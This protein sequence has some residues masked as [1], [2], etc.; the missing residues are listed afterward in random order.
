MAFGMPPPADD[1][2]APQPALGGMLN[3]FD[4]A[5]IDPA[6]M[7]QWAEAPGPE[8]E[9]IE[10]P[11]PKPI[12]WR[13]RRYWDNPEER[14]RL[15]R[16]VRDEVERYY[17]QVQWRLDNLQEW[18]RD[19]E[20]MPADG[21][22]PWENAATIRAPFTRYVVDAH[23]TR[24]NAQIVQ[25]EPPLIA[26]PEDDEAVA[27]A[28]EIEEA[29][30][31][32][33]DQSEWALTARIL[34][35]D[36]PLAGDCFLRTQFE[37]KKK[38]IPSLRVDFDEQAFYA[39]SLAGLDPLAAQMSA[40]KRDKK[41]AI[42]FKLGWE[43]VVTYAGTTFKFIP[44]EDGI[45][46][47]LTCREQQDARGIGER[48]MISGL[49]LA[50]GA[51]KGL[52]IR[53][54]VERLLK[55]PSDAMPEERRDRLENAGVE[56]D[57]VEGPIAEQEPL[58]REYDCVRMSL[59]WDGN[60]DGEEEILLVTLHLDSGAI[61]DIRYSEY[62]HGEHIYDLFWFKRRPGEVIGYGEAETIAVLQD[63]ETARLCMEANH[64][65]LTLNAATSLIVDDMAGLDPDTFEFK[66]GTI[67]RVRDV[68]G[69]KEWPLKPLPPDFAMRGEKYKQMVELIAGV[70]NPVLGRE[71]DTQKTLGE[72]QIASSNA[73]MLFEGVGEEIALQW[74]RVWEKMRSI[75]AQFGEGGQVRYRRPGIGREAALA[76]ESMFGAVPSETMLS[77]VRLV[78]AGLRQLSDMRSRLSQAMAMN[79]V[80]AANPLTAQS[81]PVWLIALRQTMEAG[82]YPARD[83]VMRAAEQSL[84]QVMM[85]QAQ[86]A[87]LQQEQAALEQAGQLQALAAGGEGAGAPTAG[88]VNAG[89]APPAEVA[90]DMGGGMPPEGMA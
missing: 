16:F 83:E 75:E 17:R 58:Y 41:G 10:E 77:K 26:D 40:L 42:R 88:G 39:L 59:R 11:A 47:P 13:V 54:E 85:Q 53:E 67:V 34:H 81:L 78:P 31:G 2:F 71:T 38:R 20:M 18:R 1:P 48:M 25:G 22:Q 63:A 60:G 73:N 4:N 82:K 66:M 61:L 74:A 3:A 45:L 80:F 19:Y 56:I 62:E 23:A 55:H 84:Q 35:H 65:D 64:G 7:S 6:G 79:Q 28:P 43:E 89:G 49:E 37:R 46:F 69:V 33:L 8:M 87:A 14:R 21:A 5:E 70:S 24:L 72:V 51:K 9:P 50:Q 76:G 90:G 86:A 36:L 30:A 27:A 52:F 68:R 32:R 29:M 44:F 57:D 12:D 15:G